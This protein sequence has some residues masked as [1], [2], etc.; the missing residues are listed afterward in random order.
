[1]FFTTKKHSYRTIKLLGRG[2]KSEVYLAI[3]ETKKHWAIKVLPLVNGK[4]GVFYNEIK[5][6]EIIQKCCKQQT[7]YVNRY[8]DFG[9]TEKFAFIVMNCR[10]CDLYSYVF[11]NNIKLTIID[12]R[13]IFFKICLGV[14][15][16][17]EAGIA[18]LDIRPENILIDVNT[19]NPLLSDFGG[20][21]VSDT[22]DMC[23]NVISPT[24][25]KLSIYFPPEL[26][27]SNILFD[28]FK[29]DMYS[30]GILLL[31][32]IEGKFPASDND[33]VILSNQIPSGCRSLVQNLVERN[34][35]KRF[36][37]AQ[38]LEH[39]WFKEEYS[40][41]I[42]FFKCLKELIPKILIRRQ[43]KN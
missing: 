31:V 7:P 24:G 26:N 21:C 20:S 14:K 34:P 18:H 19:K 11:E 16:M 27:A 30:L 40:N 43:C 12:I 29:V 37:L 13:S 3:D 28:H 9:V 5:T 22:C 25:G 36:T 42:S 38:T 6:N 8:I 17:H 23:K 2:K 35:A 33:N 15:A 32:L 4:S 39:P 10:D 1:M 41:R